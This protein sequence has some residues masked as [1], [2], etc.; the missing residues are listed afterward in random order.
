M[1]RA[2]PCGSGS[3]CSAQ[4]LQDAVERWR[5]EP[6]KVELNHLPQ[7]LLQ[8]L[9][10]LCLRGDPHLGSNPGSTLSMH[11]NRV[12]TQGLHLHT[13]RLSKRAKKSSVCRGGGA[14]GS[15]GSGERGE[16]GLQD[17][18]RPES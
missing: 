11:K 2:G 4:W 3:G 17:A 10:H 8:A 16:S 6:E 14:G 1:D 7:C 13:R 15:H 12:L 18:G 5:A 9:D